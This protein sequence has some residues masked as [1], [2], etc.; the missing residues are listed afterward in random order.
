MKNS[1]FYKKKMHILFILDLGK[2]FM[3]PMLIGHCHL[4]I[5]V[6]LKLRLQSL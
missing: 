2:V 6:P 3:V 4:Y 5:E 1:F